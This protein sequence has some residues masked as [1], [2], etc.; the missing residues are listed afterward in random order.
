MISVRPILLVFLLNFFIQNSIAQCVKIENILVDACVPG[1]GCTNASSPTCSC[2]GK[3]EMVRIKTGELPLNISEMQVTWPNNTWRGVCMNSST[4]SHVSSLNNDIKSCGFL[5]EPFDGI[6]PA[7][8][9]VLIITSEDFCV[10]AHSFENLSD[11]LYVIFQCAGNYSGHF[12][13]YGTGMRTMKISFSGLFGCEDEVTYDRSL[14]VKQDGTTGAE[15]GAFV[16]FE[17][18]GSIFYGNNGCQAPVITPVVNITILNSPP[19]CNGDT[20]ILKGS[21][22]GAVQSESWQGGTGSFYFVNDSAFYIINET[23]NVNII[24]SVTDKCDENYFAELNFAILS[25]PAATI[26]ASPSA[27]GCEGE[28]ITVSAGGGDTYLWNTDDTNESLQI[29]T[30]GTYSVTAENKCGTNIATIQITFLQKPKAIIKNSGKDTICSGE[31]VTLTASGAGDFIWN[32]EDAQ[33]SIIVSNAGTYYVTASNICGTDTTFYTI[34]DDP[35]QADFESNADTGYIP[36]KVSF[37]NKSSNAK[38]YHWFFDNNYSSEDE[39][40]QHIFYEAGTFEVMLIAISSNGCRDTAYAVIKAEGNF[41]IFIPNV[42]SP[43]ND[44]KNDFFIVQ[45]ESISEI[46]GSIFNR[47]GNKIYEWDNPQTGWNGYDGDKLASE[48][49]YFYLLEITWKN[50]QSETKA[51]TVTLVR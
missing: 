31:A 5:K 23:D 28:I 34:Y 33:T 11:T 38:V 40:P 30:S 1:G 45:S 29:T 10:D 20:I 16:S 14:L 6:L 25:D 26:N 50:N 8:S 44:G 2:E 4:A 21:F 19:F 18:N 36:L 32:S 7:Y 47:W 15:D 3:N 24:Y 22:T 46:K 13:N 37:N 12:A 48:G 35:V 17:V 49:T 9:N 27:T 51:G 39:N 41:D 43:N 42:F